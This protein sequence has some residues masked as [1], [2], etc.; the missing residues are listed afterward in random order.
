GKMSAIV[1]GLLPIGLGF[2]MWAMNPD[3]ISV[4][5]TDSLGKMLLGAA[6]TAAVIGFAWMKKLIDIEI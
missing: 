1:L 2:V 3:Y 4:L 6:M 5:F